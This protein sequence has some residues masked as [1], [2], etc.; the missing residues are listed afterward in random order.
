MVI[1]SCILNADASLTFL[2]L[3]Y[4][5]HSYKCNLHRLGISLR[6]RKLSS[7]FGFGKARRQREEEEARIKARDKTIDSLYQVLSL[8]HR[9]PGLYLDDEL[10]RSF[11][12][13]LEDL[14]LN[15][16]GTYSASN[17]QYFF[18]PWSFAQLQAHPFDQN[19]EYSQWSLRNTYSWWG[20]FQPSNE[21]YISGAEMLESHLRWVAGGCARIV[22]EGNRRTYLLRLANWRNKYAALG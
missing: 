10:A 3:V 18:K 16:D 17:D 15:E 8:V 22:P 2:R 6:I 1:G 5:T 14:E 13:S 9:Y 12:I 19:D 21:S 20:R 4:V 7:R 11:H